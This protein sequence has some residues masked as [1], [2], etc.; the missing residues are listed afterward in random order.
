MSLRLLIELKLNAWK[1]P[2]DQGGDGLQLRVAQLLHVLH[3][4]A[5]PLRMRGFEVE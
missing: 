2:L 1:A 5:E 3:D 4:G